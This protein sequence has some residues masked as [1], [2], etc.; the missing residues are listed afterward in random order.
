VNNNDAPTPKAN[1][2]DEDNYPIVAQTLPSYTRCDAIDNSCSTVK[3]CS[4][5]NLSACMVTVLDHYT[6]SF[7]WAQ[8]NFSAVWLRPRWFLVLNSVFTDVQQAALTFVTGGDYTHSSVIQGNWMLA[9][10][11]V[12]IGHTQEQAQ[13]KGNSNKAN[14]YASDA[15]P[16][17][18]LQATINGQTLKGLACDNDSTST[19]YCLSK[20]E[21]ISM[22]LDGFGM[23]QRF[24]NIYDGPSLQDSNAYL[25]IRKTVISGTGSNDCKFPQ[26]K[27]CN[28][29]PWMY[30]RVLGVPGEVVKIQDTDVGQCYLPNAAIAWKQ[31]NGFYYPPAFHSTNLFFDNVDIR[32]FVIEPQFLPEGT[33]ICQNKPTTSCTKNA[34]CIGTE[35]VCTNRPFVSCKQDKPDCCVPNTQCTGPEF[36]GPCIQ[37]DNGPCT[38][39]EWFQTDVGKTAGLYCTWNDASFINFSAIDR[40]TI[41]NDDDGSLTGL[42]TKVCQ[43]KQTQTCTKDADCTNDTGPCIQHGTVSV[44]LDPFFDA[45]ISAPECESGE[46]PKAKVG[47]TATTSPYE[48]V[49]TVVY[50]ACGVGCNGSIWNSTCHNS[51]CYGVP[52]YRQFLTDAEKNDPTGSP[53]T[54]KIRMMGPDIGGRINLT[55]NH[56]TYYISTTDSAAQ[57]GPA[58]L[59][60]IFEAGQ[61]YYVFLVFAKPE[62]KQRYQLYVGKTGFNTSSVK[63][64]QANLATKAVTFTDVPGWPKD[65]DIQY[66]AG[67]GILTVSLDL[68]S[69]KDKF[70]TATADSCQ[71]KTFCEWEGGEKKTNDKLCHCSE[72]LK[73]DNPALFQECTGGKQDIK[74]G[75]P[76]P[77]CQ[78]AVRDV[79]CPAGGCLGFRV[80]LG[81]GFAADG[82]DHRPTAQCFPQKVCQHQPTQ[83]CTTDSDCGGLGV[84]PCI[85][86]PDW[87]TGFINADAP[88]AGTC[89][90]PQLNDSA[91]CK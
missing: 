1:L 91:F 75:T 45:P 14:P 58:G 61:T 32:H 26:D 51:S 69:F 7:N 89:F 9:R 82:T 6:S 17:N 73:K 22:Q 29:S 66:D 48:Q 39:R 88:L 81:S 53:H 21:G 33:K 13:D 19:D 18:P 15:G 72:T 46:R 41:L 59:K 3:K 63:G 84:G 24:F 35:K 20:A 10:K 16:F 2:A 23:N 74:P 30:G 86:I 25:D 36:F 77:I 37:P 49:T 57:Q 56:G 60:N 85:S 80:T 8:K 87:N 47:H 28:N 44:N 12:F 27:Q 4:L 42:Q 67:T 62:T 34:D 90:N 65:E 78:W 52:L 79:D 40:Q 68:S 54:T 11:N 64:V 31:S 71:P 38:G 43:L 70:A 5:E 76:D 55:A 83:S 50:P